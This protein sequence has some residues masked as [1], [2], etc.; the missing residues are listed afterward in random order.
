MSSL[1]IWITCSITFSAFFGSF[2]SHTQTNKKPLEIEGFCRMGAVGREHL[3]E[4]TGNQPI[5]ELRG[6]ESG[7]VSGDSAGKQTQADAD[8]EMVVNAWPVLSKPVKAG[9]LAMLK[10]ATA[11]A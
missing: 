11:G 6:T 2:I 3:A 9:I 1:V 8:L 7:T 4:A 10:A 5:S